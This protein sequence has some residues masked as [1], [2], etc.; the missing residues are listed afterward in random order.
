MDFYGCE[1]HE[2]SLW[3]LGCPRCASKP[4]PFWRLYLTPYVIGTRC[5]GC[6]AILRPDRRGFPAYIMFFLI[7]AAM[8]VGKLSGTTLL[9]VAIALFID[10]LVAVETLRVFGSAES[11]AD[12]LSRPWKTK[13]DGSTSW[14]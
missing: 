1:A 11:A 8:V 10:V 13:R 9:A 12:V 7:I 2:S 6:G 3:S 14:H 4:L 5:K